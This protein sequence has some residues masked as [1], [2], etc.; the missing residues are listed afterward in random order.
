MGIQRDSSAYEFRNFLLDGSTFLSLPVSLTERSRGL[1]LASQVVFLNYENEA[2]GPQGKRCFLEM[3]P[4][5]NL[6]LVCSQHDGLW[7]ACIKFFREHMS[8]SIRNHIC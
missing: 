6:L 5:H 4:Y 3:D 7:L 8:T 1:R 2:P